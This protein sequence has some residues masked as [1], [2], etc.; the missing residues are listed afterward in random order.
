MA[1]LL[2]Q[3]SKSSKKK[4]LL[5]AII[6]SHFLPLIVAAFYD[7]AL[8]SSRG[9]E[10]S[11]L[12][13]WLWFFMWWS[14]WTSLLTIPW[15]LYKLWRPAHPKSG[16]W[17]QLIDL[18]IVETNLLS[19]VIFCWGG[20]FLTKPHKPTITYPLVG[21]IVTVKVWYFYNF[22]WHLL[23]PGLVLY[24]FWEYSSVDQL[25]RQKKLGLIASL[26]NP[27]LCLFYNMLRPHVSN[28]Y[29]AK[30]FPQPHAYP[31][32]YPYAPFF[33]INAQTASK[34]EAQIKQLGQKSRFYFWHTWPD[35]LQSLTWLTITVIFWYLV[36]SG[37]FWTLIK[38]KGKKILRPFFLLILVGF[39]FLLFLSNVI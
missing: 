13:F 34:N 21:Q 39:G 4:L 24:Y 6:F 7:K 12:K 8:H 10:L 28:Y 20:F 29:S 33:W 30:K 23:A 22:F 17:E 16:Y 36:F 25:K 11:K 32:D 14:A 37:L 26:L 35:W 5:L 31:S 19:G 18:I 1:T 15:A 9:L 3:R 27:T 2:S 38:L